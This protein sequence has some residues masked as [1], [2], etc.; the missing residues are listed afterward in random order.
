MT[1]TN[2]TDS[3][4]LSQLRTQIDDIDTQI[5][6]LFKQRM[7]IALDVAKYKKEN[8]LPVLNDRREK[9]V[10]HKVSEQIG[11]PLD[12]YARLVFNTMFDASRSYQNNYLAR[13]SDLADRIDAALEAT[14]ALFPK[15]AVVACQGVAGSHS[16][17]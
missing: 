6:E 8:G 10:L 16:T 17:A 1:D 2:R 15:K 5:T 4:D 13:R 9:E 7:E 11:E 14:P 12:G 3:L